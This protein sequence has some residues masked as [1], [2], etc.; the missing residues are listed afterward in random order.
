MIKILKNRKSKKQLKC[1]NERL[2]KTI[3]AKNIENENLRKDNL[4]FKIEI[5][6]INDELTKNSL[7]I[8]DME[9]IITKKANELSNV[10]QLLEIEIEKNAVHQKE[11]ND[12]HTKI[13]ELQGTKGGLTK[14][15][16]ILLKKNKELK[17][18]LEESMSNKYLVKKIPSGRMPKGEKI[19]IKRRNKNSQVQKILNEKT[20]D[21]E[22]EKSY[23]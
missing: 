8:K 10:K 6:E 9:K 13:K 11:K 17:H 5:D 3:K 18:Q 15:N 14:Q 21:E 19:G 22:K 12:L 16:N 2:S 23:V 20:F 4:N 7:R 1:E